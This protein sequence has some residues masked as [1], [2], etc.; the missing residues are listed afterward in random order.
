M[1][2]TGVMNLWL[3]YY[4]SVHFKERTLPPPSKEKK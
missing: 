3:Q 1:L 4:Y 2:I